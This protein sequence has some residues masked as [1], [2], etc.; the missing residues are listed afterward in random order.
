[1]FRTVKRI[2]EQSESGYA[3]RAVVRTLDILDLLQAS[4]DGVSLADLSQAAGLPKSSVFRYLSTLEGR[5]YVERVSGDSAFRLGLAF[6]PVRARH[7]D[8]LAEQARPS[9]E[10]LRDRFQETINLGVLDG[11]RVA[12]LDILE[13]PRTIRFAARRGDRDPIHSTALGKA[14][15]AH[16]DENHVRRILAAEGMPQRTR[17]TITDPD[18]F[19][20]AVER[21]RTSGFAVDRG[22]NEEDGACVAV[23]ITGHR[24]PAAISLSAPAVR[25]RHERVDE[26][27]SALMRAADGLVAQF[28]REGG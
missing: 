11:T 4:P 12:Y 5:G 26:V 13:S 7:L 6:L 23:A 22:E 15:A 17:T 9:L 3:V 24:I 21:V 14:I 1:M 28:G 2:D 19:L 25:M 27:A 18:A 16:L 20:R 8:A 10:S